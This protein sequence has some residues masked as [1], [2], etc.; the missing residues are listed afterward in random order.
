MAKEPKHPD[1][2]G[3]KKAPFYLLPYHYIESRV[4]HA[5]EIGRL[6]DLQQEY[7]PFA[8]GP[9]DASYLEF[10][11]MFVIDCLTEGVNPLTGNP[12][13][14]RD[15]HLWPLMPW[16]TR[17]KLIAKAHRQ[18][19][20]EDKERFGSR[21][22]PAAQIKVDPRSYE[23]DQHYLNSQFPPPAGLSRYVI[24]R[25]VNRTI[26]R[27]RTVGEH[28]ELYPDSESGDRCRAADLYICA[29]REAGINPKTGNPVE[30][31][32]DPFEE[33]DE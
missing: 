5:R 3:A 10:A 30:I 26:E 23:V 31:D 24:S 12:L 7:P 20:A 15:F 18:A 29:C 2:I 17:R 22:T 14:P 19:K 4:K 28:V 21:R 33:I 9:P 11:D 16:E 32:G 27:M 6:V 13:E 1:Y 25:Q 8:E